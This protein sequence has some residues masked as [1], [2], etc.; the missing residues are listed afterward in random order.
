MIG[1]QNLN[2]LLHQSNQGITIFQS[3]AAGSTTLIFQTILPALMVADAPSQISFEGGT[4]N[5][6]AP[7]YDF[8]AK[9][10]VPLINK[11]GPQIE[12]DFDR[13]GFYPAGG[14]RWSA[15]IQPVQKLKAIDLHHRGPIMQVQC[16]IMTA[17]FLKILQYVNWQ[18]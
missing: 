4:H 11:M 12:L 3:I 1:H 16:K 10:Y 5:P 6:L 9:A 8:L 13:Y 15:K 18:S 7:P 2:L 14:G 17:K